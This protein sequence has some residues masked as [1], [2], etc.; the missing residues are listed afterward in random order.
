MLKGL[1]P[2]L[3]DACGLSCKGFDATQGLLKQLMR[4]AHL[5]TPGHTWT[6]SVTLAPTCTESD[7]R[8]Q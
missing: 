1:L 8:Y 6:H 2:E 4:P 3:A 7:I 5:V